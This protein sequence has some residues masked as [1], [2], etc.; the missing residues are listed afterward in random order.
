[1]SVLALPKETAFVDMGC[2]K[3]K[4]LLLAC[5]Y[6]FRRVVG[7]EFSAELCE[8]ARTNLARYAQRSGFRGAAQIVHGDVLEY[9]IHDESVFFLYNPFNAVV[10]RALL[11]N[12]GRSVRRL[13][14]RVWLVYALPVHHA[15][16]VGAPFAMVRHL[17]VFGIDGGVN[18]YVVRERSQP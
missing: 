9:A 6:G 16:V 12:I 7:V 1:M 11:A 17:D 10:L 2:G 18:V 5:E 14:R 13:P 15:A 8:I 4:A 3:G